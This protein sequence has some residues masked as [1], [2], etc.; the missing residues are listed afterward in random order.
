MT[1]WF[2][3]RN[4]RLA[5]VAG[6]IALAGASNAQAQSASDHLSRADANGD[7][8]IEWQEV[9]DMRSTMFGRMDRNSDGVIDSKDRP[10]F[11]PGKS[12]FQAAFNDLSATADT[13]NDGQISKT[14]MMEAPAPMF[15]SADTNEDGTLS[16]DE[17]SAHADGSI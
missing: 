11:G 6:M 10:N 1:T 13:N 14:E 3:G 9:L 5:T 4:I 12:R 7:G 16:P 8:S 2:S 15:E 17:L